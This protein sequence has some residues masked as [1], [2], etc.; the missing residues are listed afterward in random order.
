MPKRVVDPDTMSTEDKLTYL[1]ERL[2]DQKDADPAITD[3]L[4]AA[5]NRLAD[6]QLAGSKLIADETRR[7]HR[8]SNEV[9]PMRSTLNPRGN[10]LPDYQK[11]KLACPMMLPWL[12]D[13]DSCSREEVELLNLLLKAPGKYAVEMTD[14]RSVEIDVKVDA[15]IDG[16]PYRMLINNETAFKNEFF[17]YVPPLPLYLRQIL[18]QSPLK[19]DA[20][21]ILTMAE[22]NAMIRAGELTVSV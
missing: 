7:A 15:N 12:A 11:P 9:V 1:I 14:G 18:V 10:L 3:V 8:P 21:G 2:A 20:A 13:D 22:E 5:L 4:A 19:R 16:T 6:A 17:K